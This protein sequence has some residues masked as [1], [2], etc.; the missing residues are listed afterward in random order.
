MHLLQ[1]NKDLFAKKDS[2]LCH[3]DTVKMKIEIGN[4]PPITLRQYSTPLNNKEI[5]DKAVDEML[6]A[7]II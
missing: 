1:D 2:E 3:T 7:K 4:Y 6:E 5:I